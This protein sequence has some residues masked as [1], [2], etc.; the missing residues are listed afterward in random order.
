[1]QEDDLNDML[2]SLHSLPVPKP[3]TPVNLSVVGIHSTGPWCRQRVCGG[4]GPVGT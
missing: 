3:N 2:E 1:M 4:G